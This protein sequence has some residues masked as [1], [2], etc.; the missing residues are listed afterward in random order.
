L[1]RQIAPSAF[2]SAAPLDGSRRR[3]Q[4]PARIT[5]VYDLDARH[6]WNAVAG[7][8]RLRQRQR[9]RNRLARG[10]HTGELK[11]QIASVTPKRP[12]VFM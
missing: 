3:A 8:E 9:R 12:Y 2:R 1:R 11:P 7:A 5:V 10:V 6:R 4:R